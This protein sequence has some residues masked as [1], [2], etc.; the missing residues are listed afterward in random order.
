MI[1][2]Q[3][4]EHREDGNVYKLV[5][6]NGEAPFRFCLLCNAEYDAEHASQG[7]LEAVLSLGIE[8][9]QDC[10]DNSGD[11]GA[12]HR[13]E[14][15]ATNAADDLPAVTAKEEY[16]VEVCESAFSNFDEL[17]AFAKEIGA[18]LDCEP[19]AIVRAI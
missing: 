8:A 17:C 15:W 10:I 2:N 19:A 9:V 16:N 18:M 7:Q 13:L 3:W 14:D 12:M 4:I 5:K 6:V 1:L 11:K